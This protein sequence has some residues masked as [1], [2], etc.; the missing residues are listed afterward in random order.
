MKTDEIIKNN[1]LIAT[2][3][4]NWTDTGLEPAYCV[5]KHK[6]YEA[7]ELSYHKSWDWLMPVIQKMNI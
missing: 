3:M 1:V 7:Y 2:F 4:N 6:G 5:F